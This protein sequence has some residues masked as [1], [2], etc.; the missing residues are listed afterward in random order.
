MIVVFIGSWKGL[1]AISEYNFGHNVVNL[2]STVISQLFQVYLIL[3]F[4]H[5]NFVIIRLFLRQ[6]SLN[7]FYLRFLLPNPYML[8]TFSSNPLLQ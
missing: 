8:T 1:H 7:I 5:E 2:I 4:F 3:R 6:K